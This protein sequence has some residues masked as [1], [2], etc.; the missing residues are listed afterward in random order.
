M[1]AAAVQILRQPDIEYAPNYDNYISRVKRRQENENL[2]K[3]L[4]EGFPAKLESDLVW[5]GRNLAETYDWNYVLTE[6][7]IAEI[8]QALRHFQCK[9]PTLP[10]E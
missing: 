3:S 4:P 1:A 6:S 2:A 8:D 9:Q 5:D 10:L 7:D